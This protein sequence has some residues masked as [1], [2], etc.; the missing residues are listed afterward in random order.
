MSSVKTSIQTTVANALPI[1][2]VS[3]NCRLPDESSVQSKRFAPGVSILCPRREP[4]DTVA[5]A[6]NSN[7]RPSSAADDRGHC[8]VRNRCLGVVVLKDDG[9]QIGF[10]KKRSSC[11]SI[12]SL[13]AAAP[14]AVS[15]VSAAVVA[16]TIAGDSNEGDNDDV[17]PPPLNDKSSRRKTI[18]SR[19][20]TRNGCWSPSLAAGRQLLGLRG[21]V[22][23]M[24]G[25][26]LSPPL[27]GQHDILKVN[28]KSKRNLLVVYIR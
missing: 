4:E 26:G 8:A 19:P 12:F 21:D 3:A 17:F 11:S 13:S 6:P 15:R 9:R 7:W 5:T 23:V 28:I 2:D 25:N 22:D 1:N 24:T 16:S 18:G 14:A 27:I 10:P 20:T